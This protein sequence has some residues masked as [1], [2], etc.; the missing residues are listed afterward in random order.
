MFHSRYGHNVIGFWLRTALTT[1]SNINHE[2]KQTTTKQSVYYG[3]ISFSQALTVR[4]TD[5]RKRCTGTQPAIPVLNCDLLL[6]K[7]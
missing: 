2:H 5:E 4:F 1:S 6:S 3:T 7:L